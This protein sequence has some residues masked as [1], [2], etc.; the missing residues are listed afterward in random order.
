MLTR[1]VTVGTQLPVWRVEAVSAEKMKVLALLLRDPNPI[2]FDVS[3]ARR[4]GMS[5]LVNQGPSNMAMLVNAVLE[6]FPG[7]R[8][9]ALSMRLTGRVL[10]GEAVEVHGEVTRVGHEV[11]AVRVVCTVRLLAE[12]TLVLQGEAELLLPGER[13]D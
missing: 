1:E 4:T 2:H 10:A 8:L 12:Q 13:D 11:D 5:A 9:T 3:A 6:A 7:G